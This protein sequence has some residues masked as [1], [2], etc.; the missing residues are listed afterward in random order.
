MERKKSPKNSEVSEK[1][2]IILLIIA[3][4]LSVFSIVVTFRFNSS[5]D[6]NFKL[7]DLTEGDTTSGNIGF[8][9]EETE[10]NTNDYA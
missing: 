4:V 2:I 7:V 5:D 10:A 1:I 8:V 3:I 9:I 6:S